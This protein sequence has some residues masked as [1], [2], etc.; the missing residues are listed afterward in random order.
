MDVYLESNFVVELTLLQEQHDSCEK[1]LELSELGRIH[2][3]VPAYSLVEPH[4]TL[5]RY[6]KNRTKLSNELATEFKQLSRSTPYKEAVNDL[7]KVTGLLIRSQE[8]EKERLRD[9]LTR[10]LKIAEVI[11]LRS[12]IL[13]SAMIFQAQHDLSPQDA[14]VYA[15]V[16]DHLRTSSVTSK[17]FLNR[18]SKDFDDPDIV[19]ALD[20]HGC[21]MLFRFDAGYSYIS[22]QITV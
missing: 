10:I 1:I 2:L 12:E 8:E 21:K 4:E 15:S 19:D 11:P 16:L 14:I 3:I 7:Q 17:C 13:S 9:A 22:G 20:R 18:N 6:A 5:I